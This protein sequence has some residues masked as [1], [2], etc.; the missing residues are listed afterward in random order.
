MADGAKSSPMTPSQQ[1]RS[2]DHPTPQVVN[3]QPET[4]DQLSTGLDT[5]K[6]LRNDAAHEGSDIGS[7][8]RDA[9]VILEDSILVD[10][11]VGRMFLQARFIE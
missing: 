3:F 1:P 8:A 11:L 6:R 4:P 2:T 7:A 10:D 5:T 9:N